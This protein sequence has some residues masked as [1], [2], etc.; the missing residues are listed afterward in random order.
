MTRI[1]DLFRPVLEE[2]L[3]KP[4]GGGEWSSNFD[5]AEFD[6]ADYDALE[7]RENIHSHELFS[8]EK[9]WLYHGFVRK[10]VRFVEFFQPNENFVLST[11]TMPYRM[12][13]MKNAKFIRS[14]PVGSI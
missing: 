5:Y 14:R 4:T 7:Y 6:Y 8:R 3:P 13:W 12:D 1:D 11:Q 2:S 10:G 9:G